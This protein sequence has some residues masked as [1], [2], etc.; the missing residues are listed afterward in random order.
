MGKRKT[1]I[2]SFFPLKILLLNNRNNS[3]GINMTKQ[4][5]NLLSFQREELQANRKCL[6]PVSPVT[7]ALYQSS[8]QR[9]CTPSASRWGGYCYTSVRI[10]FT[11]TEVKKFFRFNG[12][13]V[14]QPPRWG[15]CTRRHS[16]NES[17]P[18]AHMHQETADNLVSVATKGKGQ[19][20]EEEQ[21]DEPWRQVDK[22]RRKP[23]V[24][25]MLL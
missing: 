23:K 10:H 13:R 14:R 6:V 7:P 18:A 11:P 2:K 20:E 5:R 25:S 15:C 17:R 12:T 19:S 9:G 1:R 4:N 22:L 24:T 16:T 21:R 8:E 3:L